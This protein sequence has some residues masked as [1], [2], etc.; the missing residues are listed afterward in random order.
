MM[1]PRWSSVCAV[2]Y[3]LICLNLVSA[4]RLRPYPR[5]DASS[6]TTE[7]PTTTQNGDDKTTATPN[8][9]GSSSSSLEVTNS[10][11]V[12][13]T[14]TSDPSETAIPSAINGNNPT[15]DS[16][17]GNQTVVQGELPLPPRLTPG[18]G[19]SGAILLLTGIVY[20]LVGIKNA[21][22][23][24]CFSSAYLASLCVT[25]LIIYVMNPP[26][27]DAIQGAYVVAAVCTGLILGGAATAFRE[28]TE[29]LGCL[30]GGFCFAMWL[31]TL[32]D[33]GLLPS[34]TGKVIFIT[35]FTLV[36]FASYFSHYTRPYAL[37]GLMSFAGATVTVLGIDCFSRAGLKEFWVYIWNLNDKLF[38]LEA[39]TYPLTKGIK[40]EI[41]LIVVLT[42]LGLIS[43]FKLWRVIQHHREK[44]A[45]ERADFQ[46]MRD[47]E[48]AVV[49]RRVEED[50][51]RERRQWE[52][53]YGDMP[54]P[55]SP[56]ASRDSGVGEME[57]EKKGRLSQATV[58]PVSPT[59]TETENAIEMANL[60]T[61]D[62]AASSEDVKRVENGLVIPNQH[63]E[64][65][66]TIRVSRDDLLDRDAVSLPTPDEKAWMA[67]VDEENQH[68][69][70]VSPHSTKRVSNMT[71]PDI[72]PLP[73]RIPEP[74]GDD[75]DNDGDRSS[76]ATFADEDRR[77]ITLSKR[78][79]RA[80]LSHRLSVGSG[81]LL[82]S[83][84]QR[85]QKSQKSKR[86][87]GEFDA[88]QPSPKWSESRQDLVTE[89]RM[90]PEDTGSIAA[91][92]DGMSD[93]GDEKLEW[94]EEREPRLTMEIKPELADR[95]PE[96]EMSLEDKKPESKPRDSSGVHPGA[97]P[98]STV[99][100]VAT[101]ILD[102]FLGEHTGDNSKRSSITNDTGKTA[103][104]NEISKLTNIPETKVPS[105]T[106][107]VAKS[108]S[109]SATSSASLTK[110]RLPSSL[111]RVALS[112]R[113]N[114][115]AKHL[116]HAEKPELETLQVNEYPEPEEVLKQQEEVPA[117]VM[118]EEL[119]Q[120]AES[121]ILAAPLVRTQSSV[122]NTPSNLRVYR[123]ASRASV[124]GIVDP[125]QA[126]FQSQEASDIPSH[127]MGAQPYTLHNVRVKSRRQSGDVIQ[128]I[129][130]ENTDENLNTQVNTPQERD[131]APASGLIP[132]SPIEP[133]SQRISHSPVPGVVSY[134]SPQTLIGKRDMFLR[135]KSQSTLLLSQQIPESAQYPLRSVSQMEL[136]YNHP[137]P[138][139]FATQDPDDLP[140]SQRKELIRQNSMLSA[141]SATTNPR[142][143]STMRISHMSGSNP[144]TVSPIA[145]ESSQFNSHQPQRR[146]TAPSPAHRDAQLA[147]FRQSV[148]AELRAG[149]QVSPAGNTGRETPLFSTSTPLLGATTQ[150]NGSYEMQ[151][152]IDQQ[153][154]VLLSQREQE[155]Q[156]REFERQEKERN[157]RTFEE[158]MRRGDLMDA[159][160]EALRRM[161][162]NVKGQ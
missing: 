78:A 89:S 126:T 134:S 45:E 2:L 23:H 109:P 101:D 41:A 154:N 83:L 14:T 97:R 140:L 148:A 161:Q 124:V 136:Q 21:W 155:T 43:Q 56:T 51:E 33:G 81:N 17:T 60:T 77:S 146:S 98:Y 6:V 76:F 20:T 144:P 111:S 93:D 85:S 86:Q 92:I 90:P 65:R 35:V 157:E 145:A 57:S 141:H 53:T 110:E 40:V 122:S 32:H 79:S 71:G 11:Q 28:L 1:L 129:L 95:L 27:S 150:R 54:P 44:R 87:T 114:E 59:D 42:I 158:L 15:N 128:P 142:Q 96:N 107:K 30:L 50:N 36:G 147:N 160:R 69:T 62:D 118:V 67:G 132:P 91:T 131:D 108:A 64:N 117:P 82:R 34:T 73:F 75:E 25:V 84:S 72:I 130:E 120:T 80:S 39:N 138:S 103:G 38:P 4:G 113:T 121:G 104:A 3:L 12:S 13:A 46:R 123:S 66:V 119:Q 106:S 49:G 127:I 58:Q 37:I 159:H 133:E 115:W 112:Y 52:T 8:A 9:S 125:T 137:T 102:P 47:E 94:T 63:E 48:E 139:P 68:A 24:T 153:R 156:R 55:M 100:T 143:N 151:Y 22:L 10:V 88:P 31:L 7:G 74:H 70:T 162:S 16:Y 26:I 29:G 152:N 149:T 18:W 105:D 19:V 99:E 61:S 116:S 5:Q 135:S